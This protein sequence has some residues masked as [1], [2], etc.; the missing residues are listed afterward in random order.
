MGK[1]INLTGQRFGFWLVKEKCLCNK[2]NHSQWLC[3][4]ECGIEKCIT[5]NS[6]RTGN[7]TSC[8]CNH[9]P[10][11]TDKIFGKLKVLNINISDD[12]NRRYWNCKCK[13]GNII[14]VSTYKLRQKIIKSC[15]CDLYKLAKDSSK[16]RA[17]FITESI[18]MKNN[19]ISIEKQMKELT[20]LNSK[21]EENVA[22]LLKT[23]F[24]KQNCL[25]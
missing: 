18:I 3:I 15:G 19:I 23:I 24:K 6:L 21:L 16:S 9:T 13:C 17:N 12:K 7:S 14:I 22:E 20:T 8:G 10:D 5:S 4:C 25:I 11:L 2:D 1:L